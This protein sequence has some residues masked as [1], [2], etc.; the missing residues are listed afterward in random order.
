MGDGGTGGLGMEGLGDGGIAQKGNHAS[1]Q[2]RPIVYPYFKTPSA[3]LWQLSTVNDR[4]THTV[5]K[6]RQILPDRDWL[7]WR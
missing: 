7:G 4:L 1:N 2:Q 5:A 3:H 6:I